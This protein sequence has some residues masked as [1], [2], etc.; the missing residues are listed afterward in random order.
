MRRTVYMSEE[1]AT[2]RIHLLGLP[3]FLHLVTHPYDGSLGVEL[4]SC[5]KNKRIKWKKNIRDNMRIM[6]V[7]PSVSRY[8]RVLRTVGKDMWPRNR[9]S[10]LIS[11]SYY[12][13]CPKVIENRMKLIENKINVNNNK[14]IWILPVITNK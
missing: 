2:L 14:C 9:R 1:L 4:I 11:S 10:L 13:S 6:I 12:N 5:K 7:G 3:C 8:T